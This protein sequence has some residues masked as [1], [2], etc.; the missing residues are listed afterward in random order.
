MNPLSNKPS[1]PKGN[2][3]KA[4]PR[5][6]EAPKLSMH[7]R[8]KDAI[9]HEVLD[10]SNITFL[11]ALREEL[12]GEA[13]PIYMEVMETVAYLR[14]NGTLKKYSITEE[15]AAAI[16]SIMP[17]MQHDFSIQ[18][19]ILGN[20][21]KMKSKLLLLILKSLRMLPRT[22]GKIYFFD[23]FRRII[24]TDSGDIMVTAFVVGRRGDSFLYRKLN[25]KED[26]KHVFLAEDAW[27]YNI[28][29]F[30]KSGLGNDGD[31][32]V[33][34]FEPLR[35]FFVDSTHKM[36]PNQNVTCYSVRMIEGALMNEEE[37]NLG[38]FKNM[39]TSMNEGVRYIKRMQNISFER[40]ININIIY[41]FFYYYF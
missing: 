17:L 21:E 16:T 32:D 34:V 38:I 3:I 18:D 1:Q 35:R 10:T 19:L 2:W 28:K 11:D 31:E 41:Y 9:R 30:L 40:I 15:E 4:Q 8:E 7:S 37:I 24:S 29:D 39:C 23:P 25:D 22:Y 27:G 33:I 12:K 5:S 14:A 20:A 26:E 13:L 36:T 6:H